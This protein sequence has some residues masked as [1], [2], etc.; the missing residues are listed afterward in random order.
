M[1]IRL[2][3]IGVSR[4]ADGPLGHSGHVATPDEAA[5]ARQSTPVSGRRGIGARFRDSVVAFWRKGYEENLTGMA[6]MVAYTLMLSVFPF[7]LVALF[8]AGRVLRSEELQASVLADL[9]RIF[10]TAAETTLSEGVRRLQQTSPTVGIV[11]VVGS[12]WFGSSFWGALDTAFCRIY[13]CECRT[14]VQQKVFA[15]GMFA[16]VLLFVAAT[17]IVPTVQALLASGAHDLPLGLSNVKGLV[18]GVTLA[19]GVVALFVTLCAIYR[20]VPK[21]RMP[22]TAVW[23]GALGATVAIGIVDLGFPLYLDNVSTLRIG[24]S[25]VFVLIALVWFYVIALI[26][27][28]G[29]VINALR[30]EHVSRRSSA[31]GG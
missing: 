7:A 30:F 13:H 8:I 9:Q 17:V 1:R 24:T 23:P 19:I 10:P 15:V 31:A 14:W 12:I 4:L 11:A 29:A 16:F 26:V 20:L 22:W 3:R 21:A 5:A 27:L 28:A 18:Y 6:G 25:A 2:G